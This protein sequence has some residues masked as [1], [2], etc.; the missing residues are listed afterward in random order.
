MNWQRLIGLAALAQLIG[1]AV[2]AV[3]REFYVE[4]GAGDD[5]AE[6]SLDAPWRTLARGVLELEPGDTLVLRGGVYWE[7]S[8][9]IR[10][11]GTS[12]EP[13][14]IRAHPGEIPV[15]DGGLREFRSP[16]NRD[17]ELVSVQRRIYRSTRLYP[18]LGGIDAYLRHD[19]NHYH[20]IPYDERRHLESANETFTEDGALY[21]GQG[22]FWDPEDERIYARL[23]P[24]LL[25]GLQ[26]VGDPPA[27]DPRAV[28]ID[29][30]PGGSVIELDGA[31]HLELEGLVLR[32]RGIGVELGDGA[33][34]ITFRD[35]RVLGG[36]Y[37]VVVQEDCHHL[38]FDRVQIRDSIPPWV[39]WQDVKSGSMPANGLQGA[40]IEIGERSHQ[41][42]VRDSHFSGMFDGIDVLGDAH[43]VE[44]HH[45]V[46]EDIR[47]DALELGTA[48]HHHHVHHNRMVDSL[49]AVS[50]D[51]SGSAPQP[52]TTWVHHNLI[53]TST[54]TQFYRPGAEMEAL[55][56]PI[57]RV[58]ATPFGVH[59]GDDLGQGDAW[60]IYQ[61]T[62]VLG[63]DIFREGAGHTMARRPGFVHRVLNN[64]FVQV[65]D[66]P[67]AREASAVGGQQIYD[68]NLYFRAVSPTSTPLFL[69]YEQT[70]GDAE[71]FAELAEFIG[72]DFW[73]ATRSFYPPG[74]ETHSV[75][76]DPQLDADYRP[77]P[78]AAAGAV[79]LPAD[80]PDATESSGR[81]ALA[82]QGAVPSPFEAPAPPAS[83]QLL[84]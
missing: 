60:S 55:A 83:P 31:A 80:L 26:G 62:I 50:I 53:D 49:A 68:G 33:H 25:Q 54:K 74:W 20:L 32:H 69:E 73:E 35:V 13:I 79:P 22:V 45:S 43:D 37:H 6:G 28:A 61:N 70:P 77:S 17:W 4:P 30:A 41:I 75:E 21:A 67:V 59:G 14:R 23:T 18:D 82:P 16:G 29:I 1:G 7:G 78:A 27:L 36:S 58:W 84:D 46:F 71:S 2:P 81:G 57:G 19:G 72:S 11:Q 9:R 63:A 64:I 65:A 3:A 24:P 76:L 10:A 56:D 39:A 42:E 8:I 51:G 52:G 5:A 15:I 66:H 34:H 44:I 12:T 47:D 40:G 38:T 48:G